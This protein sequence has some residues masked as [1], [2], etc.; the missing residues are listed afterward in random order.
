MSYLVIARKFRPQT[1]KEV[2]G[3][4]HVA[5][6][7]MNAVASGR[8]SHAYLLTGTRGIGKTSVARIFAKAL[9]CEDSRDG[10]PCNECESCRDIT[11]G[12]HMDVVEID[13]ASNRGIDDIRELREKVNYAS[14]RGGIKVY[15]IDEVH[16]ITRDAFNALLKTLEEPPPS[17]VFIFATTEPQKLPQTI[18]SR[19]QRFDFRRISQEEIQ[20]H[21]GVV[22]KAEKIGIEDEA[23][24]LVAR[25]ADGSMRDGQSYLDLLASYG[26]GVITAEEAREVLGVLPSEIYIELM[27]IIADRD[28]GRVFEYV[29][30]LQE[31]A[32]DYYDFAIE[33]LAFLRN[34][35]MV[36]AAPGYREIALLPESL[37]NSLIGITN[38]FSTGDLSRIITL[39]DQLELNLRK[40]VFPRITVETTLVRLA[41]LATT[42]EI[43]TLLTGIGLLPE[44]QEETTAVMASAPKPKPLPEKETPAQTPHEPGTS[45]S[46]DEK[47]PTTETSAPEPASPSDDA[48]AAETDVVATETSVPESASPSEDTQAVETG[49]DVSEPR[50]FSDAAETSPTGKEKER[51]AA[52]GDAGREA[53]GS[54]ILDP[55]MVRAGWAEFCRTLGEEHQSLAGFL[56]DAELRELEENT[57]TIGVGEAVYKNISTR[58]SIGILKE[59]M[60]GFFGAAPAVKIKKLPNNLRG[61]KRLDATEDP[62]HPEARKKEARRKVSEYPAL[63]KLVGLFDAEIEDG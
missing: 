39:A 30:K 23:L 10:E 11:D 56:L 9:N 55:E 17:V 28:Q 42:V 58:E 14:A 57:L 22:A 54:A 21:L 52:N 18:L 44:G 2:V 48:S 26:S 51:Q 36:K 4:Q 49:D 15:I 13:G 5:R 59:G 7:L 31:Q 63:E 41:S 34:A 19:C 61:R 29:A 53:T 35:L 16:Q 38:R 24:Y 8:T 40:A 33:L 27:E 60:L 47:T 20:E 46:R 37:R 50:V 62:N 3:Q 1:F 43:D 32:Y 45:S 6:T 25:K 12:S